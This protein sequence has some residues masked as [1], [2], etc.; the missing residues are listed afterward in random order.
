MLTPQHRTRPGP[1]AHFLFSSCL[2]ATHQPVRN[3][4]ASQASCGRRELGA[5]WKLEALRAVPLG[6]LTPGSPGT[7]VLG[8][9]FWGPHSTPTPFLCLVFALFHGVLTDLLES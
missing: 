4:E 9:V 7:A 2:A 8:L 5:A 3:S 1:C 6:G